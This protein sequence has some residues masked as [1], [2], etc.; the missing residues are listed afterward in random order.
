MPEALQPD[1]RDSVIADLERRLRVLESAQRVGL[2]QL[3]FVRSTAAASPTTY[4]SAEYGVAGNTWEDD[5]GNTGTGY[6]TIQM[7]TPSKALLMI[8]YRPVD[9]G[10]AAGFKSHTVQ[11][12]VSI[13]GAGAYVNRQYYQANIDRNYVPVFS[14]GVI[15]LTPGDHTFQIGAN[16]LLVNPGGGTAPLLSDAY[17]IVLP[18]SA[19]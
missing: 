17:M 13:D 9:V 5:Q 16:W 4:G 7:A 8:G 18:L 10:N 2:N 3:R 14:A 6:P 19:A 1:N 15:D 11:V 12:F